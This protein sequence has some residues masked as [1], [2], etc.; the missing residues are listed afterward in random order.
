MNKL[1]HG[2]ISSLEKSRGSRVIT[3]LTSDRAPF[4]AQ[5]AL[6]VLPLFYQ[7][8]QSIKKTKKISLFLF[9]TGGNLDAPW[10]LV[11]MIREYCD[12]FEVI[13]PFKALSA[14]TLIA[15]G[16]NKIVMT[17][18]SQLSPIDPEGTFLMEGKQENYSVEDVVSYIEFAK[19][20][21]GIAES[22]PLSEVLRLLAQEIKPHILGSLNRTHMRIR[23]LAK[24]M[25]EMHLKDPKY[26]KDLVAIVNNLTQLLGSHNHLIQ[27][28]EARDAIG[29]R[30]II[31]FADEDTEK[32]VGDIFSEYAKSMELDQ[33]FDPIKLSNNEPQKDIIIYRAYIESLDISHV[34]SSPMKI[35]LDAA[36]KQINIQPGGPDAWSTVKVEK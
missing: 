32:K 14:A 34:F 10:P 24:S 29:F 35:L 21:V 20:K 8:L 36:T 15:L 16:A 11:N 6:D 25:L 3:Y 27:R 7:T 18:L 23:H 22:Q 19:D 4:P 26:D 9:S 2:Q 13:I 17:P 33:P 31:E 28:R 1:I 12:E 5:I 30:D